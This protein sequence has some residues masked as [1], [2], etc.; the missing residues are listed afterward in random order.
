MSKLRVI[1]IFDS[2][3]GEGRLI[4]NPVSF[5]RLEGCN[6]RCSWC[7]TKYSYDTTNYSLMNI[8]EVLR[9]IKKFSNKKVCITGGEPL[10]NNGFEVLFL[11]LI[12]EG[13]DIIIETNGTIYREVIGKLY[14]NYKDKIYIVCSPKPYSNYTIHKNL[15][16]YISEIKLVVDD[17]LDESVIIRFAN[18]PLTLQPEG[19]KQEFFEKAIK[20]QKN[21]IRKNVEVRIIP[22]I[23][24]FFN[25]N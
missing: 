21:L 24:K 6:L 16:P 14:N 5:I 20:L 3:E 22:Q 8:S 11:S 12:K 9:I 10:F 4:G 7:D 13:Y 15:R 19:N 1:E 18:Y 25:I 2:I 23:H 17:I